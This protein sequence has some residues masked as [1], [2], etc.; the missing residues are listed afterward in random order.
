[1]RT[2]TIL[3]ATVL[4]AGAMLAQPKGFTQG[5]DGSFDAI[6]TALNL[7]DQQV[8][9]LQENK[10]ASWEAAQPIREQMLQK[11]NELTT[12]LEQD[13]PNPAVVGQLGVD[14]AQLRKDAIAKRAEFVAQAR[15]I[16]TPTQQGSLAELVETH[17]S[18]RA[19]RQAVALLLVEVPEGF[20]R[21]RGMRGG[22]WMGES[23]D[24][25][26]GPA[27]RGG[28]GMG[29]GRGS[30]PGAPAPATP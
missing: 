26:G 27:M 30:G 3:L 16:L 28:R 14:I 11:R 13:N 4:S 20:A 12:E 7:T 1:M 22:N 17:S 5:R 24:M 25:L 15:N 29:G 9:Q 23:C 18:P 19:V 8:E 21:G 10:N 2:I 6:K